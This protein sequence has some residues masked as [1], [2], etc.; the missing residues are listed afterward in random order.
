MGLGMQPWHETFVT[1]TIFGCAL[2]VDRTFDNLMPYD[3]QLAAR[4]RRV[5]RR[6]SDIT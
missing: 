4:I 2:Q 6:R 3:E 5:L 1:H